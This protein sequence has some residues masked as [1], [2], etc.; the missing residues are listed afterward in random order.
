MNK[1]SRFVVI[2]AF[3]EAELLLALAV[4]GQDGNAAINQAN[5]MVRGYFN[6]GINLMYAIGAVVG[7][8]GAIKVYRKFSEGEPD[9]ARVAAAWFGACIFL[10]LVATVIQLFFGVN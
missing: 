4:Y 7:L 6:T 1:V 10:V 8:I 3:M 9:T 2:G 5:T